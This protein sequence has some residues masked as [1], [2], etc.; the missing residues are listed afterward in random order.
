MLY[1]TSAFDYFA[2]AF[3][4]S[5]HSKGVRS[6]LASRAV[7]SSPFVLINCSIYEYLRVEQLRINLAIFVYKMCESEEC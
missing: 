3:D 1:F 6:V 4:Y 5:G 2:R 7:E